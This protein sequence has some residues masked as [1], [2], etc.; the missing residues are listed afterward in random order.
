MNRFNKISLGLALLFASASTL[1]YDGTVNFNG[2]IIDNGCKVALSSGSP[3][4]M[5]VEMKKVSK[6]GLMGAKGLTS[7]P[8]EF[9]LTMTDCPATTAQVK[10]DG[11]MHKSDPNALAISSGT[12]AA[13]N[14][15]IQIYDEGMEKVP[16]FTASRSFELQENQE[17]KL[18]FYA[19]YIST[20]DTVTAGV[21]NAFANFTINYN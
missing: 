17:N 1:A 12:S 14:I 21:A 5:I 20:A 3:G 6:S 7:T 11:E 18:K 19:S 16:M 9:N 15:A 13:E 4:S 2:Q 8:V 10:F